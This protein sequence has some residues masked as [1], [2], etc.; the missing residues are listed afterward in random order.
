MPD[1]VVETE[2]Q[3]LMRRAI[4]VAIR[5]VIV[6]LLALWCLTLFLPFL[7]LVIWG[8]VIAVALGPAHERLTAMLGGRTGVAAGL[9]IAV[10]VALIA[11]PTWLLSESFYEGLQWLTNRV[12]AGELHLPPPPPGV[13]DWPFVGVRINEVWSTASR[14]LTAAL[15]Q[16][17]FEPASFATWLLSTMSSLGVAILVTVAAIIVA[18]VMLL[19][20][21][22]G[23]AAADAIGRRLAGE[24]GAHAVTLAT[25]SIRSVAT[26]VLGV[27]V[28]QSVLAALGLVLAGVPA[29]GLW[30]VLVL[31]LAVAQLPPLIVLGPAIAWVLATSDS[32]VTQVLFTVW[33]LV[34]SASDSV[35]KP[36]FLGRG[37]DIPMPVILIGAIGGMLR[38]GIIGLFV[39]A[40]VMAVG[41]S[42]FRVWLG[43]GSAGEGA[44]AAESVATDAG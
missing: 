23:A 22:S 6:G 40:V 12:D 17:G 28:V 10:G 35:L 4:E 21:Q 42:I 9:F 1:A 29:A 27:A 2:D 34:V 30:A 16:A 3:K 39:G 31:V 20:G 36:M 8:I 33:S 32:T 37:M 13:A 14:D 41:Y 25:Q 43:T 5:L 7:E 18:G 19:H 26:G 44:S 15:T 38:S 11:I 24:Q